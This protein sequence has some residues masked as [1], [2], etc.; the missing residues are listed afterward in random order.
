MFLD[1]PYYCTITGNFILIF[2][3]FIFQNILRVRKLFDSIVAVAA[4]LFIDTRAITNLYEYF[5]FAIDLV[6]VTKR[7]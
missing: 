4:R 5:N 7:D 6:G 2:L 3:S 1:I